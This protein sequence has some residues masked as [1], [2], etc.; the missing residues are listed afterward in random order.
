MLQCI[1][2]FSHV[3]AFTFV[4]IPSGKVWSHSFSQQCVNY[5]SLSDTTRFL[6]YPVSLLFRH[7]K[8]F[9]DNLTNTALFHVQSNCLTRLMLISVL[10]VEGLPLLELSFTYSWS[11]LNFFWQLKTRVRYMFLFPHS[12]QGISSTFNRVTDRKFKFFFVPHWSLLKTSKKR[13]CKWNP[14]RKTLFVVES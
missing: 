9:V 1:S 4:L 13:S 11:T 3:I 8:I 2:R 6:A 5:S 10:L 12:F 7:A 14:M